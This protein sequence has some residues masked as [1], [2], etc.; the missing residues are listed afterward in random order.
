MA[1]L[2]LEKAPELVSSSRTDLDIMMDL[3]FVIKAACVGGP[4]DTVALDLLIESVRL[5]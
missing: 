3:V 1:A 2:V 4:V 5:W